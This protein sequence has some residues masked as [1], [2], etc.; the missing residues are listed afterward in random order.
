MW[1]SVRAQWGRI[2]LESAR[3][4]AGAKPGGI[5]LVSWE[6]H[7]L[8]NLCPQNL[9]AL[10]HHARQALRRMRHRPTLVMAFWEQAELFP[11]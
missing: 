5:P 1:D 8:P 2:W 11:L 9:G 7:E 10:S 3:L 6:Q 4:R